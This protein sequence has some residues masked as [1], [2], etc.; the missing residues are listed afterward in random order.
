MVQWTAERWGAKS[1]AVPTPD[2]SRG[3]FRHLAGALRLLRDR[4]GVTQRRLAELAACTLKQISAYETGRQR[5]RIETLERILAVLDAD[6]ADLARAMAGLAAV[7]RGARS[8]VADL[9]SRAGAA[10]RAAAPGATTA[11]ALRE[12]GQRLPQLQGLADDLLMEILAD[13]LED[14]ARVV[15]RD[16]RAGAVPGR[17]EGGV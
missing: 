8:A 14:R 10:G 3:A 17:D 1:V 2:P 11:R 12:I 7:E 9:D 6:A 16:L 13:A 15:A 5:P 4:R